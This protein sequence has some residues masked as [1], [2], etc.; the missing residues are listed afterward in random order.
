MEQAGEQGDAASGWLDGLSGGGCGVEA[1]W[2]TGKLLTGGGGQAA[3]GD[4]HGYDVMIVTVV[5]GEGKM[6]V[7]LRVTGSV[8]KDKAADLT[9]PDNEPF[10]WRIFIE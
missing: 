2:L 8:Q 6:K 5:N 9:L 4:A 7:R 1:T 3:H 10:G